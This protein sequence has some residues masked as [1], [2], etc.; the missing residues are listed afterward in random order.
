MIGVDEVGRGAWAGP[1]LVVGARLKPGRQLPSG[2]KDSKMLSR[3]QRERLFPLIMEAFDIGDGWVSPRFI[4]KYGLTR[5]LEV[6]TFSAVTKLGAQVTDNICIDGVQNF[7]HSYAFISVV[8]KVKADMSEPVVAAASIA[9]KV[10]RDAYMYDAAHNF[11]NY[12]FDKHVGY[13]TQLH[14]KCLQ[15]NGV[16][17]L[18]RRSFKPVAEFA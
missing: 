2:L 14:R 15:D 10:M 8:T 7:L 4:D 1:L 6:A 3:V 11:P 16:C 5:A 12:G 17:E 13:G 9:A 18:H